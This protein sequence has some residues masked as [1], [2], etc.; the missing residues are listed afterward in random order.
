[1]YIFMSPWRKASNKLD[2]RE[3]PKE[4]LTITHAEKNKELIEKIFYRLCRY[5]FGALI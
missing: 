1:M 4:D 5:T 2:S 3:K